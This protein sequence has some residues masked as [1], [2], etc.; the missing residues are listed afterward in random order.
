MTTTCDTNACDGLTNETTP[1]LTECQNDIAYYCPD[2]TSRQIYVYCITTEDYI[3]YDSVNGY[4]C[5]NGFWIMIDQY[6]N[7]FDIVGAT[8]APQ[9][10]YKKDSSTTCTYNYNNGWSFGAACSQQN[11]SDIPTDNEFMIT[12]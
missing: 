12:Y 8:D 6:G 1:T 7:Y 2:N 3:N 10:S 4:V 5:P 9:M 11:I